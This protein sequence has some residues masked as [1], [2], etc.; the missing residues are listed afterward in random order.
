[1]VGYVTATE[2]VFVISHVSQPLM[3]PCCFI[4]LMIIIGDFGPTIHT[5]LSRNISLNME[6]DY[7][8]HYRCVEAEV[9]WQIERA[10]GEAEVYIIRNHTYN[11]IFDTFP[12][13]GISLTIGCCLFYCLYCA[14]QLTIT[15][16]DMRYDGAQIT[17]VVNLP[18]CFSAPNTTIT[19]TLRIQG[20][21]FTACFRNLPLLIYIS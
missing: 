5:S 2:G 12:D 10:D 16:T 17:G 11:G 20:H 7:I 6:I 9:L 21:L 19:T 15:P 3:N 14:N 1:M 4:S 18:E 8:S 13:R